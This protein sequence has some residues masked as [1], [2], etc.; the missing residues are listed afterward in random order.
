MDRHADLS[1]FDGVPGWP[2]AFDDVLGFTF[3]PADYARDI[4]GRGFDVIG[5][6]IDQ[7]PRAIAQAATTGAGSNE[8]NA[9]E[10]CQSA[11]AAEKN[12]LVGR[13]ESTVNLTDPQR[14]ALEKLRASLDQS[15]KKFDATCEEKVAQ[16]PVDRLSAAI[17]RLWAVRDAGVYIRGPLQAFY[18]SLSPDQKAAFDWQD[19]QQRAPQKS[20]PDAKAAD[21][22]MNSQF[23]A[24]AGPGM[25]TSERL[26]KEIEKS[27][28]L[29]QE[30]SPAM[31]A[32]RKATTDMAKFLS[33]SCGEAIAKDPLGRLD[34]AN[35]ELSRLSYAATSEQIALNDFY[36]ALDAGQKAKFDGLGH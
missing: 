10:P 28:D 17:Q 19:P 8:A 1:E 11:D 30:Q 15:V 7:P 16:T 35:A 34:A 24:C 3:W 23:Q 36:G 29:R 5:K 12:W 22:A 2:N 6:T 33:A 9:A 26:L 21:K 32:L 25:A 18:D 27:S 20:Q 31:D 4:H 13:I 14:A